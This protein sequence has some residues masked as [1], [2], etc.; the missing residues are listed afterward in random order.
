V[1]AERY[2]LINRALPA[3]ELDAY[4]D[5]LA[6]AVSYRSGAVIAMHREVL[7]RVFGPAGELMFAGLAA[8]NDGFRA[9]MTGTEM[10]AGINA[11]LPLKQTREVELDLPATIARING[12]PL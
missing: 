5:R 2:G 1:E 10:R 8:E 11:M 6:K 9:A 7:K 4:V 12:T 3:R